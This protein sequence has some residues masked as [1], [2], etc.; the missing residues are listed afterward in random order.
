MGSNC[1]PWLLEMGVFCGEAHAEEDE[2]PQGLAALLPG[3]KREKRVNIRERMAS[4][5]MQARNRLIHLFVVQLFSRLVQMGLAHSVGKRALLAAQL[6]N[7][8]QLA[9]VYK[10][11]FNDTATFAALPVSRTERML[12][13]PKVPT[14][15]TP[16]LS[17][18]A[19]QLATRT[20]AQLLGTTL[21]TVARPLLGSSALSTFSVV[22]YD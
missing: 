20:G 17:R 14:R 6:V 21:P 22:Y 19:S 13:R 9:F 3:R 18:P 2:E 8:S 10:L 16:D 7:A 1:R 11:S 5:L 12:G 15:M 4:I